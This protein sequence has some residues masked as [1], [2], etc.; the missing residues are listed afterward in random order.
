MICLRLW[1]PETKNLASLPWCGAVKGCQGN[2]RKAKTL[3]D[4]WNHSKRAASSGN[5]G[6]A[7]WASTPWLTEPGLSKLEVGGLAA[8]TAGTGAEQGQSKMTAGNVYSTGWLYLGHHH[9]S[10]N[11]ETFGRR[12]ALIIRL[13]TIVGLPVAETLPTR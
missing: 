10:S 6:S 8:S 13:S 9:A 11:D 3:P 2:V 12:S 1:E 7:G 5:V 4:R